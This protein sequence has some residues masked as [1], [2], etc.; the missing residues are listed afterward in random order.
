[1]QRQSL[2]CTQC[3]STL[4]THLSTT[5]FYKPSCMLLACPTGQQAFMHA[6]AVYVFRLHIASAP[7]TVLP[8]WQKA[9]F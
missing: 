1:M 9:L 5:F 2:D 7:T 6:S 8:Y 4:Q 3:A